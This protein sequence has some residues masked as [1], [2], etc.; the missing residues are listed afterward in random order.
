[1]SEKKTLIEVLNA[2]TAYLE[3]HG[4]EEARLNMQHLLAHL[5]SCR[6]LDLYLRYSEVMQEA[7]LV[8]LRD[9]IKQR[10]EG[11]PLQHLLGTVEFM[12]H[13]LVSDHRALIPRPETEFLVDDLIRSYASPQ[14]GLSQPRRILDMACGSGCIGLSLAKAWPEAEVVLADVSEEALDLTR[15]NAVRLELDRVKVLRSDLFEKIQGSFDLIVSNLPYIPS[16]EIPALSR[17]VRCDPLLALDGGADG[18]DLVRRFLVEAKPHLASAAR[19]ALEVGH[20]QGPKTAVLITE[21]GYLQ[22]EV[23]ADL[24]GVPRFVHAVSGAADEIQA[25]PSS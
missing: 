7:D 11:R 19:I 24:A 18:L 12:G 2:G 25:L 14:S 13:E 22:P 8:C 15:L 3:R 10:G 9:L 6:R 4:I 5:L 20:D 21:H 23:R 17:E 16:R 1:M